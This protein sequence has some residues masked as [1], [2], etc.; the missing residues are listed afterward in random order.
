MKRD[1]ADLVS[2][3]A[4]NDVAWAQEPQQV[5]LK[6]GA[7]VEEAR[8]ALAKKE[9]KPKLESKPAKKKADKD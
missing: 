2:L 8:K 3:W 5:H 7:A 1:N 9:E 6:Y 4:K